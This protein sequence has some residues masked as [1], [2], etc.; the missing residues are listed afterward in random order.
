MNVIQRAAGAVL[1]LALAASCTGSGGPALSGPPVEGF[2][3]AKLI[4]VSGPGRP[5]PIDRPEFDSVT[6]AG[7]ADDARVVVVR[8]TADVR[9]Y[10]IVVLARRLV[11][12]DSFGGIDLVVVYSPLC[13]AVGVWSRDATSEAGRVPGL[14]FAPAGK[15]YESTT[16]LYD[17][18][19]RSLWLPGTGRAV[20]GELRGASLAR[21]DAT[22]RSFAELRRM[23]PGAE[24]LTD[25]GPAGS[26][27]E[28]FG[29]DVGC[30]PRRS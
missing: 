17:R 22:L 14:L 21:I 4:D 25:G 8:G 12:N 7:L 2:R 19:T 23:E 6:T 18:Q 28:L 30:V 26:G 15:L 24:V 3:D 13:D 5:P 27:G 20:A 9:A 16:V 29:S 1:V 10:P 11:V